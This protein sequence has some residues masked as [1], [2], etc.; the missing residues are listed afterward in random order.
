MLIFAL[1]V[2]WI[3][4]LVRNKLRLKSYEKYL[5]LP[6]LL[7][8]IPG[9]IFYSETRFKICSELLLVPLGLFAFQ[10]IKKLIIPNNFRVESESN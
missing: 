7:G 3:Y 2:L 8:I 1:V 4:L 10:N 9:L 6:Y 5:P